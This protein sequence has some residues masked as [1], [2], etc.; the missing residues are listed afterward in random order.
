M[1][2]R[3]V[4]RPKAVVGPTAQLLTLA[5][6]PDPKTRRWVPRRKAEVVHAVKGGLLSKEEAMARYNL[7]LP[8]YREWET[9]YAAH[10]VEGLRTTRLNDYRASK[11]R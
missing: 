3:K 8:E 5:D 11:V 6:L 4:Q 9:L 1:T 2:A 10:G 7:T